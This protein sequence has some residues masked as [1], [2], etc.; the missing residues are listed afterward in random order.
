MPELAHAPSVAVLDS[1]TNLSQPT[2]SGIDYDSERR[3]HPFFEEFFALLRYRNLV[4]QLVSR[5]IKTRYKRSVLGVAWTMIG[6]LMMMTV[7]T[8]V[9]SSLMGSSVPNYAVFLL[10]GFTLWG[11]FQQTSAG[12][13]NELTWGG[14]L[15]SKIYVPPS[16]FAVSALGSGLV[17]LLFSLVPLVLI[18]VVTGMPITWS[19]L[20]LP[21]PIILTCMFS[22]GIGLVLARLAIFFGDVVEMYGILLMV[23]FYASPIIYS[24]NQV[25]DENKKLLLQL[26]PVYYLIEMFREPIYQG[27]LPDPFIILVGTVISV[28]A[29]LFGWWFFTQKV[30]EFAYRV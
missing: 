1:D 3:R 28:V 7:L 20:F 13:M 15:L 18:M 5:N 6:P 4:S 30:D 2:T 10:S 24:V 12:I 25:N 11:F 23:W 22:L 17:N 29:L 21:V 14:S 9:F 16:A 19:L 26:N 8:V 27:Q